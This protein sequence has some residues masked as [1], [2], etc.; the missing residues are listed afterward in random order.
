MPASQLLFANHGARL[1]GADVNAAYTLS[2]NAVSGV[3]I[4]TGSMGYA[5]GEDST[6]RTPL[7]HVM[8]FHGAIALQHDYK[9]WSSS[10]KFHTVD[11]KTDV[12][13]MRLEPATPGYS[14]VDIRT[15]YVWRNL[16]L[17]FAITN[18][19][20]RQHADPLGGTWQSARYP[21]GYAAAFRPLPAAGRSFDTGFSAK[22]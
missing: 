4:V 12:D 22:F 9:A 11:R 20:D 14:L 5:H 17:D 19:F 6:T 21:P 7:Y 13:P 16:R 10:L 1:Y 2:D 3:F 8:P 18:L 15:A